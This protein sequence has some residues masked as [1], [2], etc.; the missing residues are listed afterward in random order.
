MRRSVGILMAIG[1]LAFG[2]IGYWAGSAH[3]LAPSL[4]AAADD[5]QTFPQT[6]KA[7]CGD[8]LKYWQEHGALAQ[9]G[10]PISDVFD[11]KSETDG[12]THKVQYFERAVF[13]AHPEFQ[14]PNNVLLSLLG[15]QKY[16]AKYPSGTNAAPPTTSTTVTNVPAAGD[17]VGQTLTVL[18]T[19]S[20]N[21]G[22]F[23]V[24]VTDIKRMKSLGSQNASGVYAIF[25]LKVT[26]TGTKPT[27]LGSDTVVAL[28]AQGRTFTT[29]GNSSAQSAAVS[30]YQ[31]KSYYSDIQPSLSAN[32]VLVYDVAPDATSLHLGQSKS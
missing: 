15:S 8:F 23:N 29:S 6:G 28:D 26:N 25:F 4:L 20:S 22:T 12:I 21:P 1:L 7:A 2:S 5:C 24:A 30:L 14:P 3:L 9:Q 11:E 18:K 32:V 16:K 17:S 31:G 13:E 10:Y 27:Y 19:S